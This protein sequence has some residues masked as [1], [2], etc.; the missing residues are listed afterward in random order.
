MCCVSKG[1]YDSVRQAGIARDSLAGSGSARLDLRSEEGRPVRRRTLVPVCTATATAAVGGCASR[2][3]QKWNARAGISEMIPRIESTLGDGHSNP[4]RFRRRGAGPAGGG[5]I[6]E[7]DIFVLYQEETVSLLQTRRLPSA[8][9]G[10]KSA[11]EEIGE[12]SDPQFLQM[13]PDGLTNCRC[14]C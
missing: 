3:R 12:P 1:A 13:P 10:P 8:P 6:A 11:G 7:L 4:A 9:N 14:A 5:C 2:S